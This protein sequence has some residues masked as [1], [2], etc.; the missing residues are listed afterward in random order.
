MRVYTDE[1]T[2]DN[3]TT[4]KNEL[5]KGWN[6]FNTRSVLSHVLMPEGFAINIGFKNYSAR[7]VLLESLIG[8]SGVDDEII[9]PGIRSYDG[10]YTELY[11][12][13]YGTE[14]L[15]QTAVLDDHQYILLT[16]LK[17][18]LK[19]MAL[20]ISGAVLWYK[21]GYTQVEGDVLQGILPSRKIEVFTD[22]SPLKEVHTGLTTPYLSVTL[23]RPVAISTGEKKTADQVKIIMDFAKE[24]VLK[25]VNKYGYLS[26]VYNAMRTCM[27]WDTIY[28]PERDRV[29]TPVSRIWNINFGGY[30]LFCW[31]STPYEAHLGIRWE[32]EGVGSRYGAALESGL[33]NSPMY[34]DIAFD[35]ERHILELADVGL[36]SLYIMD[37]QNLLELAGHICRQSC[38]Q[39]L[40]ER[41]ALCSEGLMALWDDEKGIFLNKRRDT[42]EMDHRLSPCN[43]YPLLCDVVTKDQAERMVEE[44]FYN[45]EEFW[46]DYIL[47]SIARYDPAYPEQDYW[48]GRIWAPMNFLVYMGLRHKGLTKA[49]DDLAEK[50]KKLLLLEWLDHGHVHENYCA[51]TGQGCNVDNSDKFYH[52]GG[53]LS[54]IALIEGGYLPGCGEKL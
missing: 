40:S 20:L 13:Y 16:P 19:A 33:D 35:E 21:K 47:P 29:C 15:V 41:L 11:I 43:F 38:V 1:N 44:H 37:C 6:T 25:E 2:R 48:R 24:K 54:L 23:D 26:E 34:D 36:T 9:H 17:K 49:C 8:R 3:Y 53:L 5:L 31:G 18:E 12:K 42:G 30:V 4:I 28:E 39:E 32:Y 51:D 7:R 10:S 22:G 14:T 50:S 45:P 27:A 46:G 52:W